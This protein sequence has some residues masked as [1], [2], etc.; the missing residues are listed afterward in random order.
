MIRSKTS[1]A[2]SAAL[3]VGAAVP[4]TWAQGAPCAPTFQAI[5]AF[6]VGDVFQYRSAGGARLPSGGIWK[7]ESVRKYRIVSQGGTAQARTYRIEGLYRKDDSLPGQA[8]KRSF[9]VI[10]E[11]LAFADSA[12][13]PANACDGDI[14]HT[15]SPG[16]GWTRV[17]SGR[18]KTAW[19]SLAGPNLRLKRIGTEVIRPGDPIVD[20]PKPAWVYAEGL[21]LVQKTVSHMMDPL[22]TQTLVG[23]VRGG[24]TTG[25][26]AADAELR[27]AAA[28]AP[29]FKEI[30]DYKPGDIF[31]YRI[32]RRSSEP[33]SL[34]SR[35]TETIR[36]YLIHSRQ[37]S[38]EA[39]LYR[40]SGLARTSEMENGRVL[41]STTTPFQET[42]RLVDSAGRRLDRCHGDIVP[43][44]E[45]A[46]DP[47]NA[48]RVR[49]APADTQRFRFVDPAVNLKSF[50]H[51]VG[52]PVNDTALS[53]I[54]DVYFGFTYAPGL[55][56]L[57]RFHGGGM[58]LQV[59]YSETLTGYIRGG[60][61]YGVLDPTLPVVLSIR[62]GAARG[63]PDAALSAW[64]LVQG[65]EAYDLRGRRAP[66]PVAPLR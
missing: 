34:L 5:H 29:T 6:Q 39:I 24:V 56:L 15:P 50:G 21:G 16:A 25:E 19:F 20:G 60:K 45:L 44:P 33:G 43:F 48:T 38:G 3:L 26:I 52:I 18:G 37:D 32:W 9:G 1:T 12:G 31:Q 66:L 13:H 62:P 46:S 17:E 42:L 35:G 59:S 28:C 2:L 49:I 10:D 57:E 22:E 23:W 41:S 4:A 54:M 58:M 8:R 63:L 7:W 14:V 27:P 55:G 36:K 51:E 30:H 61:T 64:P 65:G 11:T 47:R 40:I 53:P